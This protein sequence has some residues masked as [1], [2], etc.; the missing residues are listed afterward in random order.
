MGHG[1]LVVVI[2]PE[3]A[4]LLPLALQATLHATSMPHRR[5]CCALGH[6]R[7]MQREVLLTILAAENSSPRP[8]DS[9]SSCTSK[10]MPKPAIGLV[11]RELLSPA[12]IPI[13]T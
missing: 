6:R 8:A 7:C 3:Q 1:Q 2:Q 11:Q 4:L 9:F 12:G 13:A 10:G 5:R